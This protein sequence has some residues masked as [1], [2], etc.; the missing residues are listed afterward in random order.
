MSSACVSGTA[1]FLPLSILVMWSRRMMTFSSEPAEITC[2]HV[3][4]LGCVFHFQLFSS[5]LS[6]SILDGEF[7]IHIGLTDVPMIDISGVIIKHNLLNM[8][9][10]T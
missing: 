6:A 10:A 5:T 4:W 1:V 3:G 9:L 8:G 7:A 2:L